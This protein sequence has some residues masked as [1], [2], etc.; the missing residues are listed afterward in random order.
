MMKVIKLQDTTIL[1]E[2][3]RVLLDINSKISG[4]QKPLKKR[5]VSEKPYE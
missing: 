3:A 1:K 4:V 5:G 2:I